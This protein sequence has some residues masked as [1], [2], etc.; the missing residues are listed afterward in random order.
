M[1][2]LRLGVKS[3]LQ[4]PAYV[5]A[6]AMPDPSHICN[7]HRSSWQ[8][9]ILDPLSKARDRTCILMNTSWVRSLLS[10]D[11]NSKVKHIYI[12]FFFL[13]F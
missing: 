11:G 12:F 9:G 3:E 6:T 7:L 5:T 4:L 10:H 8:C 13:S 2:I 1:E